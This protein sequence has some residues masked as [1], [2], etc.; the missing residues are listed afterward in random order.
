MLFYMFQRG[1]CFGVASVK[2]R[3]IFE[4]PQGLS[5]AGTFKVAGYR[6]PYAFLY[7]QYWLNAIAYIA[8]KRHHG[9]VWKENLGVIDLLNPTIHTFSLTHV[10]TDFYGVI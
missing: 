9:S 8:H 10:D 6:N 7:L 1:Q 2:V 5:L 4:V 3:L